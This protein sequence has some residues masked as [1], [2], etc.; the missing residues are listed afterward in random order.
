MTWRKHDDPW[1]EAER[2]EVK[3]I[4]KRL[5]WTRRRLTAELDRVASPEAFVDRVV[6]ALR[7]AD[8]GRYLH[9]NPA[10]PPTDNRAMAVRETPGEPAEMVPEW[11]EEEL[12][13]ENNAK[14]R[15]RGEH[16]NAA[17]K[18]G[19][20]TQRLAWATVEA[21]QR[22]IPIGT[23]LGAIERQLERVER[24]LDKLDV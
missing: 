1:Q 11:Y 10:R 21:K 4:C 6:R 12:V 5:G 17:R 23:Q 15:A 2:L 3:D 16:S 7:E 14:D 22:S 13:K 9:S 20:L 18:R 8:K 19:T 24:R